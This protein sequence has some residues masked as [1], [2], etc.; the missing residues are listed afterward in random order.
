MENKE[1]QIRYGCRNW[2]IWIRKKIIMSQIPD[3]KVYSPLPCPQ[4][5]GISVF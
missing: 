2:A 3:K 1:E 4:H 5:A